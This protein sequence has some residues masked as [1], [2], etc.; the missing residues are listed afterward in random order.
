MSEIIKVGIFTAA[1][2]ILAAF[3][4]ISFSGPVWY[5]VGPAVVFAAY[6]VKLKF[7]KLR[8]DPRIVMAVIFAVAVAMVVFAWFNRAPGTI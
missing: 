3:V 6:A 8:D 4:I 5:S 1:S 7:R 2:L